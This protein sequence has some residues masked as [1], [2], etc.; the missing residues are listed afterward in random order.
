MQRS[1]KD[2]SLVVP[3]DSG[4]ITLGS[5]RL[6]R[7]ALFFP[8]NRSKS[9]EIEKPSPSMYRLRAKMR[10]RVGVK[11]SSSSQFSSVFCAYVYAKEE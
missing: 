8:R 5:R 3:S 9:L 4:R 2:V 11:C 7:A 1:C 6:D 10:E